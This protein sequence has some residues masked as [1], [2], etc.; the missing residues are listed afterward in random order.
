[1]KAWEDMT[2]IER[3]RAEYSD[4]HKDVFGMRP[5][6][7]HYIEVSQWSDEQLDAEFEKLVALLD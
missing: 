3:L 6:Q 7:E 4:L 1:M 2:R 5:T